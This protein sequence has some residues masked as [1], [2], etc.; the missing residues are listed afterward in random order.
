MN[1]I[2]KYNSSELL[3]GVTATTLWQGSSKIL[4]VLATLYCSNI[5]S[6]DEF[7]VYS[8][9]KNTLILIVLMCATNFSGLCTKFA[10]E[11]LQS[12]SSLRRLYLLFAFTISISVIFGLIINVVPSHVINDF[13]RSGDIASNMRIIGLFLPIFILQP[14]MSGILLGYK[15]FALVGKYEFSLALPYV[16][17]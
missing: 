10:T 8:F 12:D 7:G 16:L 15:E 4:F 17:V 14:L 1:W 5:L 13:L 2:S 3:K 9:V 6:P 11:S